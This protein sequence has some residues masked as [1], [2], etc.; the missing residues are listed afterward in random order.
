MKSFKSIK[1]RTGPYFVFFCWQIV[2]LVVISNLCLKVFN[3][4]LHDQF[5]CHPA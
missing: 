2:L 3:R 5:Q 1:D 4:F